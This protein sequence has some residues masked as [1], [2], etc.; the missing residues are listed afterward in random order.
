MLKKTLR[1]SLLALG[2]LG[3][4][5][6][7]ISKDGPDSA[8][9]QQKKVGF[10]IMV[11]RDGQTISSERRGLMTKNSPA[12]ESS[13]KTSTMSTDIP[14]GLMGVDNENYA[15]VV[16]NARVGYDGNAFNTYLNPCYW[17]EL[18]TSTIAFSAY[19]PYVDDVNYT[20]DLVS[21]AIPYSVQETDAGPLV[22]KTVK[23]AVAMLDMVPL[24]FQ[25]ITN[26]IGYRICDVT[27]AS[28]LQGLVHLRKLTA[29][30]VASA[31]VFLNDMNISK[32]IWHR[33]GYYRDVVVFEGDAKVGVGSENEKFVSFD[34]LVD[35]IVDSHRYYS[36]PDEIRMGKQY[37]EVKY[38]IEGFTLNGID[39]PPLKDQV[40]RYMLYGLLPDNVFVYGKQY[41]FHIGIDLSSVYSKITFAPSVAGWENKIYEN[42]DE[43]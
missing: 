36:I 30:N 21:Y 1:L 15:L 28:E 14:F 18:G 11:T 9:A 5:S 41:T 40:C 37:V 32:G 7:V 10:D 20:Q 16:D 25:H 43:F 3:S 24:E 22:S 17:S 31:G 8:P 42:N 26:D 19:Y 6:C 39:Y 4:A 13:D 12:V 29:C 2:L 23:M 33:Q 34:K 38:D 27:P 35:H